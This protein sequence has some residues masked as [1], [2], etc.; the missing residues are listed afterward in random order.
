MHGEEVAT[1]FDIYVGRA[2]VYYNPKIRLQRLGYFGKVEIETPAV[3]GTEDQ[4]DLAVTVEETNSG[5]F[6]FGL[7]YSQVQGLIASVSV[8]QNNFFGSGD[9][10]GLTA[11]RSSFI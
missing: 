5:Q 2:H 11:Q 9:R 8:S 3:A 1:L 6:T 7:G 10:I 4:V